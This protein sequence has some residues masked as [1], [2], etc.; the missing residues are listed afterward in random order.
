MENLFQHADTERQHVYATVLTAIEWP[1]YLPS[2][3]RDSGPRDL[4][5]D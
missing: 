2:H 5:Y 1:P 4:E 3:S